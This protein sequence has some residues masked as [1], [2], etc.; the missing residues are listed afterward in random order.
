MNL[1]FPLLAVSFPGIAFCT[2]GVI[3]LRSDRKVATRMLCLVPVLLGLGLYGSLWSPEPPLHLPTFLTIANERFVTL[4]AAAVACSGAF[5]N[6]S[7]KTSSIL[8]ALGGLEMVFVS[9]FFSRPIV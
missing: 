8:I 7:K 3:E 2:T 1:F 6:F 5:I 4:I 9:I